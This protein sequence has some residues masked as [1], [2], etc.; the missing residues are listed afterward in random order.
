MPEAPEH[1]VFVY[2]TLRRGG[3][4]D[5]NRL[6]PAPVFVGEAS[7]R[8]LLYPLGWYPGLVLG[9]PGA[10]DVAGEVYRIAPALQARL[11]AIEGIVPGPDSEY[12]KREVAVAVR[13]RTLACLVYEINAARVRGLAPIGHGDW[14]RFHTW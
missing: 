6:A 8:G 7:V 9:G 4:N 2:G 3:R 14:T 12:F 10:V 1:H 11:D 5:I 13:G